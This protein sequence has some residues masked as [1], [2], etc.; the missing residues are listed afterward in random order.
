VRVLGELGLVT[1]VSEGADNGVPFMLGTGE[2]TEG[3]KAWRDVMAGVA[4]TVMYSLR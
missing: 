2:V 4:E 3:G 1:A